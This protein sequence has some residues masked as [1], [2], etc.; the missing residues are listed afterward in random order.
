LVAA[1]AGS[2]AERHALCYAARIKEIVD[3][4]EYCC[5]F[6]KLRRRDAIFVFHPDGTE[7][8][9]WA[10]Y[11][12]N[13]KLRAKDRSGPVLIFDPQETWY[14]GGNYQMLPKH[15]QWSSIGGRGSIGA[16]GHRVS[17]VDLSSNDSLLAWLKKR[18]D[19]G[20]HG[21]PRHSTHCGHC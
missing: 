20:F 10:A 21:N 9:L 19:P 2:P 16:Q 4:P 11:H 15:L 12:P 1:F 14:F 18:Y 13:D 7:D 17:T 3:W 8:R 5:R 6:P